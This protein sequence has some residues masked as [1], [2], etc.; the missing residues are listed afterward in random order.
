MQRKRT[1]ACLS[2]CF[3]Y[4]NSNGLSWDTKR[5]FLF[6]PIASGRTTGRERNKKNMSN[7][8]AKMN[9]MPKFKIEWND[10]EL[11]ALRVT[12]GDKSSLIAYDLEDNSLFEV[13]ET[14]SPNTLLESLT[15]RVCALTGIL[16]DSNGLFFNLLRVEHNSFL[17]R[18]V[19]FADFP[20]KAKSQISERIRE[21]SSSWSYNGGVG[22]KKTRVKDFISYVFYF[23]RFFSFEKDDNSINLGLIYINKSK[24]ENEWLAF[25]QDVDALSSKLCKQPTHGSVVHRI[26]VVK[27]LIDIWQKA[28]AR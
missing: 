8:T 27:R 10:E 22:D 17:E 2:L 21:L 7:E 5:G 20:E 13:V 24:L 4:G 15:E 19:F 16:F 26:D 28:I 1:R 18:E 14:A 9:D 12:A 23:R 11:T 3:L 6:V 25:N